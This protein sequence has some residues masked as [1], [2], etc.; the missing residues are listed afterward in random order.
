MVEEV[1]FM[2]QKLYCSLTKTGKKAGESWRQI[3]HRS[4]VQCTE[5]WLVIG[6]R[7]IDMYV[8]IVGNSFA[9]KLSRAL[10]N[11]DKM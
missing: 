10:T 1:G 2:Q 3:L 8:K 9:I 7:M 5:V 4:L 11:V 6:K